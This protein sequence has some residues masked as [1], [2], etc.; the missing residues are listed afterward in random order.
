MRAAALMASVWTVGPAGIVA[1][2]TPAVAMVAPWVVRVMV[3]GGHPA[4]AA[5]LSLDLVRAGFT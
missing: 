5:P 1:V 2:C 3:M 4:M